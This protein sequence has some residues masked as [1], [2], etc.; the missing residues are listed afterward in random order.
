MDLTFSSKAVG[1]ADGGAMAVVSRV[2]VVVAILA[3]LVVG[4]LTAKPEGV[5]PQVLREMGLAGK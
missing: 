5:P 1:H 2:V 3:F 4:V